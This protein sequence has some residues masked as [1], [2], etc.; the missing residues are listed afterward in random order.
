MT[1][2]PTAEKAEK[3]KGACEQLLSQE[4]VTIKELSQT[5]GIMVSNFPAV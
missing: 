4:V 5:I 3:I 2:K 1:V